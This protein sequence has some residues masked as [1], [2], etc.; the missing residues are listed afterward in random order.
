M[1]KK[2]LPP[3]GCGGSTTVG[4]SGSVEYHGTTLNP[5]D[6]GYQEARA[7]AQ[8]EDKKNRGAMNRTAAQADLAQEPEPARAPAAP[9]AASTAS[10]TE[11]TKG[12]K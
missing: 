9:R 8:L 1:S 2:D 3:A 10:T 12:G 4:E 5:G 7:A 6:A 11:T